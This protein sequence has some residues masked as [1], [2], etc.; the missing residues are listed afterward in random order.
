MVPY[1]DLTFVRVF[2]FRRCF[3]IFVCKGDNTFVSNLR[4][5]SH[6][7]H[8]LSIPDVSLPISPIVLLASLKPPHSLPFVSSSVV[9]LSLSTPVFLCPRVLHALQVRR[10]SWQ[11]W[12][13]L[14]LQL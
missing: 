4:I 5:R 7:S 14:L 2:G 10:I 13:G 9:Q 6:L 12:R 1:E 3:G 8:R 11:Q